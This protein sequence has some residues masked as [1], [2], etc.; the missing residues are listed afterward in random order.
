MTRV[1]WFERFERWVVEQ[2]R[3]SAT[4]LLVAI[5]LGILAPRWGAA[6][7]DRVQQ[8]KSDGEALRRH[9][10]WLRAMPESEKLAWPV[11]SVCRPGSA[12]NGTCT[13]DG[14]DESLVTFAERLPNGDIACHETR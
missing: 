3:L 4:I 9:V 11:K 14:W 5:A 12:P 7:R 6:E 8:E 10:R 2:P 13:C 1:D